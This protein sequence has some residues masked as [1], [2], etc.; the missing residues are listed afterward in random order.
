[1]GRQESVLKDFQL[2]TSQTS[3]F[4]LKI[5]SSLLIVLFTHARGPSNFSNRT[6][7]GC[8]W[9]KTLNQVAKVTAFHLEE[10][11]NMGNYFS[12]LARRLDGG[13][14]LWM[15]T[16]DTITMTTVMILYICLSFCHPK[17]PV[18]LSPLWLS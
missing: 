11:N 5:P 15:G 13:K 2:L 17:N 6:G 1:M 16:T 18:T 14:R 12:N 10:A 9:L 8:R 4:L 7:S 3:H